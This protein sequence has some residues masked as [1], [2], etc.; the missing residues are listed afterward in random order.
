ML[1]DMPGSFGNAALFLAPVLP[2]CSLGSEKLLCVWLMLKAN[3]SRVL[4]ANELD[5]PCIV[6]LVICIGVIMGGSEHS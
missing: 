6:D 2:S 3:P 5:P 1:L 4:F